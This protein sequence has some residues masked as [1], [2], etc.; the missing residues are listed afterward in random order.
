MWNITL[1]RLGYIRTDTLTNGI[2]G[3]NTMLL[4]TY[5]DADCKNPEKVPVCFR[6][7]PLVLS[8]RDNIY[9]KDNAYIK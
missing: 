7:Y 5:R 8:D 4:D 2:R 3:N 6:K 1:N 9:P